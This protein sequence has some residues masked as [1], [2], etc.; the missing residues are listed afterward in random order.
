MKLICFPDFV[1]H[2]IC[3]SA[4]GRALKG[5][6]TK[7]NPASSVARTPP[8]TINAAEALGQAGQVGGNKKAVLPGICRDP[9]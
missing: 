1:G 2:P 4:L 7:T 8:A 9:L 3:F 5:R 6:Q